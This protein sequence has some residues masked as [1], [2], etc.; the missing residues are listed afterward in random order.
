M[1]DVKPGYP[2]IWWITPHSACY[3][4]W[5]GQ[6]S[7]AVRKTTMQIHGGPQGPD[8]VPSTYDNL[9]G[10]FIRCEWPDGYVSDAEDQPWL[11]VSEGL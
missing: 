8:W 6:E 3:F 7:W 2:Q 10:T 4:F 11:R 1:S 5:D 9:L